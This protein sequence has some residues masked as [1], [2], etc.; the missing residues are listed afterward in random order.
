MEEAERLCDRVAIIDHG[1]IIALGTQADLVHGSFGSRSE[2]VLQCEGAEE[3]ARWAASLGGAST[4]DASFRFTVTGPAAEIARI[5][6]SARGQ[7][8]SVRD[9]TF[10]SPTVEAVFLHLTGRELRE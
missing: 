9:L 6:E 5:V 4:G 8:I 1:K 3:A 10:K 2:L 7:S